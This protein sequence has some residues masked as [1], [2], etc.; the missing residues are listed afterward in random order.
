MFSLNS[1]EMLTTERCFKRMSIK[2]AGIRVMCD[3]RERERQT[4]QTGGRDGG[5][6]IER[7]TRHQTYC[8]HFTSS[9][10]MSLFINYIDCSIAWLNKAMKNVMYAH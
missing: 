10:L 6:I 8:R 7:T 3:I 1:I 5:Q 2:R 9:T 4:D